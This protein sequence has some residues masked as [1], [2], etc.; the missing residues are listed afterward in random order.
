MSK[1]GTIKVDPIIGDDLAKAQLERLNQIKRKIIKDQP[2][3]D[4][5][6]SPKAPL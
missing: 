1:Q 2:K 6:V 3:P 5:M 4:D